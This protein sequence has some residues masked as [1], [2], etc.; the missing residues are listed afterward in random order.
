MTTITYHKCTTQGHFSE[1]DCTNNLGIWEEHTYEYNTEIDTSSRESTYQSVN[2]ILNKRLLTNLSLLQNYGTTITPILDDNYFNITDDLD[3]SD[4]TIAIIETIDPYYTHTSE[5]IFNQINS[6]YNV[7][8]TYQQNLFLNKSLY[9]TSKLLKFNVNHNDFIRPLIEA[10]QDIDNID[11]ITTVKLSQIIEKGINESDPDNT[12]LT[13]LSNLNPNHAYFSINIDPDD[14]ELTLSDILDEMNEMY[15]FV[16]DSNSFPIDEQ[17]IV[18]NLVNISAHAILVYCQ[19]KVTFD[20][21]K[22]A[23]AKSQESYDKL[24]NGLQNYEILRQYNTGKEF[25]D[26]LLELA[27]VDKL[28][29]INNVLNPI[30]PIVEDIIIEEKEE[31]IIDSVEVELKFREDKKPIFDK[32]KSEIKN[33]AKLIDSKFDAAIKNKL[34]EKI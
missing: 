18:V 13:N 19:L 10:Q 2:S 8:L 34:N 22:L 27:D 3:Y 21:M 7:I 14:G 15:T 4:Y 32:Y 17:N 28:E 9:E 20:K 6:L 26:S 11:Y 30:E 31:V 12:S 29:Q 23:F 25:K 5:L 33:I 16:S 1:S 24:F